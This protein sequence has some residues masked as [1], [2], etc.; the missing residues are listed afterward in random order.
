MSP[1]LE[2][3]P[4]LLIMRKEARVLAV[5]ERHWQNLE[6]DGLFKPL[7]LGACVRYQNGAR[8]TKAWAVGG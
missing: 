8:S 5:T 3:E 6:R 1:K 7:R 2:R 4:P